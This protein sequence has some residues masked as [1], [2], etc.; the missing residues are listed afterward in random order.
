LKSE[1][2]EHKATITYLTNQLSELNLMNAKL[3][4]IQK[5][6][7]EHKLTEGAKK[8][9]LNSID[10]AETVQEATKVYKTLRSTLKAM[11]P[12]RSRTKK[13]NESASRTVRRPKKQKQIL[14][15]STQWMDRNKK[16]AGI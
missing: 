6:N 16:L 9:V 3:H 2:K 12:R 14:S 13:I 7:A 11:K 5:I 1:L 15:E 8:S 4:Y 10:D